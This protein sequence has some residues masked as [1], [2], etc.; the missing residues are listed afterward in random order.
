TRLV[1][2]TEATSGTIW[3]LSSAP[4]RIGTAT[5]AGRG[6][7][8]HPKPMAQPFPYAMATGATTSRVAVTTWTSELGTFSFLLTL[9]QERRV[10]AVLIG[11]L[12]TPLVA[13][14]GPGDP[15]TIA[16]RLTHAWRR[17]DASALCA[18]L[19]PRLTL[20]P[21]VFGTNC[22]VAAAGRNATATRVAG[23][24]FE[25]W[26]ADGTTIVAIRVDQG[27]GGAVTM[28][29]VVTPTATGHAVTGMLYDL[30]DIVELLLRPI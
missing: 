26:A 14:T 7:A 24:A 11:S 15:S 13:G 20:M 16:E 21:A 9:T 8:A 25:G 30:D 5:R 22:A 17:G 4:Y 27:E 1:L 29:H 12:V 19:H 10:D 18:E 6:L 2:Y 28:H 23:A 3:R